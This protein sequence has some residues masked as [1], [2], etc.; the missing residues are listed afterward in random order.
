MR[1]ILISRFSA[2]GDVA[3]TIPVVYNACRS[4]PDDRFYFITKKHQAQLF[5]NAPANLQI[6]AIDFDNYRGADGLWRL[7]GSLIKHFGIDLY[8]D[9]HDVLRTKVLRTF[10]SLRGV[11]CHHIY[12][13][14][15]AKKRLTRERR[16]VLL[17]LKSTPRRYEEVFER[18][19]VKLSTPFTS[20]FGAGKGEEHEF[21][22]VSPPKQPGEYWV[23]IAPFAQHRGKIYPIDL[24]EKV[25]AKL[26]EQPGVKIFM[27]G[28][29]PEE[30][31][32]ISLLAAR[33]NKVINMAEASIGMGAELALLSHC[34]V[35]LS[36]DS[37]NMHLASLVGLRTVS[38][39]GATHPYA[40]F[41]GFNQSLDDA[42]QLDM[43]CR[44]CSIYGNKPC[45]RGDY[46]C[47]RGIA[48][49]MILQKLLPPTPQPP[50]TY[51]PS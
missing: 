4:N 18:G 39:W 41:M 5:V 6:I 32:S 3:M 48:P 20:L 43:T 1:S 15:A 33:Y 27:F 46:H 31:A 30:T 51:I 22:K 14:R 42:V 17:Q 25:V 29:G 23:A 28:F 12:K 16:K 34:D 10:M 44:P 45:L 37:A 2:L 7:A 50:A 21:R 47:L 9:L 24:L 13:G 8:L 11:R 38:I 36:M 49:Q 26:N 40:G 35:M 19:G